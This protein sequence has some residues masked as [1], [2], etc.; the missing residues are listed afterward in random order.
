MTM[1]DTKV[2]KHDIEL[3]SEKVRN[4][5]GQIPPFLVRSG[6]GVIALVVVLVLVVCYFIPYSETIDGQIKIFS[7]PENEVFV[8]SKQGVVHFETDKSA[9]DKG[10]T[11]GYIQSV[12]TLIHLVA[13]ISGSLSLNAKQNESIDS[14]EVLYAITPISISNIYGRIML[15]YG[16]KARIRIGQQVRIELT[17]FSSNEYGVLQG[18]IGEIYPLPVSG[19]NIMTI[20]D[21][22]TPNPERQFLKVDVYLSNGLI[23]SSRKELPFIP[24]MQG[25][26]TVVLSKKRFLLKLFEK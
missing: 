4:I 2:K 13:G 21:A 6:I 10:D 9:I 24:E 12:D 26:A 16:Y 25:T 15:P 1:D 14:G 22:T 8:S 17:G 23:T 7:I 19:A 18:V 3:R 11:I 5:I 20:S